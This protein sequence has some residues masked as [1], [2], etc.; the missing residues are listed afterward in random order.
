MAISAKVQLCYPQDRVRKKTYLPM[1]CE[2]SPAML[3]DSNKQ[4]HLSGD[5]RVQLLSLLKHGVCIA[6]AGFST[7]L[8]RCSVKGGPTDGVSTKKALSE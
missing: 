2:G 7:N 3:S 5:E 6:L 8:S 4:C 1:F